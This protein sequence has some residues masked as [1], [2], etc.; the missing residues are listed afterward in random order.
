MVP[1]HMFLFLVIL[2]FRA[3]SD[4]GSDQNSTQETSVANGGDE[5]LMNRVFA[6]LANRRRRY[7]LYY[8]RD[9]DQAQIDDLAVQIAAWEQDIPISEVATEY[10]NRVHTSLVHLHLPKLED[11]SLVEYDRRSDM[12][13][14]T[15]PPVLLDEAIELASSL[16]KPQ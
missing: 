11:Y 8:L 13:C 7:I 3:M 4:D 1:P 16:E 12:V 5:P 2:F 15:Y 6:A 9:H 10:V 14:Y